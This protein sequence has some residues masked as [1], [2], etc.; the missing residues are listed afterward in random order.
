MCSRVPSD[1][2]ITAS[3]NLVANE[4]AI[5]PATDF[6]ELTPHSNILP[7]LSDKIRDT[8]AI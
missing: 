3:V 7:I 8:R 2:Q 1:V 6:W 5:Q 4:V